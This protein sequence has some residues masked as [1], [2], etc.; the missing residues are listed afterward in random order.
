MAIGEKKEVVMEF[1]KA[2]P[3]GVATL[4][5][6]GKLAKDQRPLYSIEQV[7]EL[8]EK[9]DNKQDGLTFDDSPA[10]KSENPVKSSG[11]YAALL[12]KQD[13]ITGTQGQ[14]VGFNGSGK[15]A[16]ISTDYIVEQGTSGIWSY[17]KWN[18]GVA[19]C[20]GNFPFTADITNTFG[21]M[22]DSGVIALPN[23]PFTYAAIPRVFLTSGNGGSSWI[24]ERGGGATAASTTNPGSFYAIRPVSLG[25]VSLSLDIFAVGRWK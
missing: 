4:G 24:P 18:S 25:G 1:D 2:T 8:Q 6:D 20:W 11:V 9:L 23:F 3:N 16:P 15:A 12:K 21:S 13:A 10:E 17:R 5:P 22:Y 14:L 19:E 7:S